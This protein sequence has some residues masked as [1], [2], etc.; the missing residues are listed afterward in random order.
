MISRDFF[1]VANNLGDSVAFNLES[2][3]KLRGFFTDLSGPR[4]RSLYQPGIQRQDQARVRARS[5]AGHFRTS[6]ANDLQRG[7]VANRLLRSG[8]RADAAG[9]EQCPISDR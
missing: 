7:G 1:S 8:S 3:S 9:G 5:S 2:D 4:R 6:P